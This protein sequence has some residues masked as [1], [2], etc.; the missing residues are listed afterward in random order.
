MAKKEAN[1]VIR[2]RD[3]ASA[4]FKSITSR[5]KGLLTPL[6]LATAALGALG[7][8]LGGFSLAAAIRE[9]GDFGEQ[10]S[11]LGGL[12]QAT[13]E[14]LQAME[15][16]ARE[17]GA[18]TRFTATEAGRGLEELA[19]G[20]Q[21]VADSIQSLNPVLSL[22]AGNNQT[23]A[24]SAQ[25]VVTALNAFGLAADE[26]G[27]VADV[28]TRAAQRT[29]QTT[30]ELAQAMTMVAP[31]AKAA[32]LSIEETSAIIGRL[33]DQGFRG[34]L[35]GTALRNAL[36]DLENPS[37]NFRAELQN[38]GVTSTNF[39]D[40]LG[41][42]AE[43]GDESEQALR[44]LGRRSGPAIQ[45][46]VQSGSEG[47][48]E[49]VG[50]L[51]QAEGAASSAA[52]AMED[53][54]P[55]AIRSL[56][57]AFADAQIEATSGLVDKLKDAV[58]DLA[59]GIRAFTRS[60]SMQQL[61]GLLV[62]TFEAAQHTVS[63]FIKSVDFEQIQQHVVS[64]AQEVRD[65]FSQ[66]R[67]TADQ[68]ASGFRVAFGV[69]E[70]AT[71]SLRI[72]FN[73]L[74]VLIGR[75]IDIGLRGSEQL[76]KAFNRATLGLSQ[77]AK[78]IEAD[79]GGFRESVQGSIDDF[80]A[81]LLD[82]VEQIGRG[83]DRIADTNREG[84]KKAS[85]GVAD[86]LQAQTERIRRDFERLRDNAGGVEESLDSLGDSAAGTADGF[87]VASESIRK[88]GDALDELPEKTERARTAAGKVGDEWV[89]IN[90]A[91]SDAAESQKDAADS[92]GR[93][94]SRTRDAADST[95]KLG[96]ES[97]KTTAASSRLGGT[98][99]MGAAAQERFNQA[100]AAWQGGGVFTYIRHY[101]QALEEAL[102]VQQRVEK[103]QARL[104]A[105]QDQ[106]VDITTDFAAANR[107]LKEELMLVRG[108][109]EELARLRAREQEEALRAQLALA[110]AEGDKARVE[111]VREHLRL[112]QELSREQERQDQ[113]ES[114]RARDREREMDRERETA[115][116]MERATSG[117]GRIQQE[118]SV[119]VQSAIGRDGQPE[120]ARADI[121]RIADA[122]VD[123]I[124][125]DQRRV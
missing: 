89:R 108:Q 11:V 3:Q 109:E 9:A 30:G 120:F 79:I 1:I 113:Q 111:Q 39:I 112:Q 76:V 80:Q 27:R 50:E 2:L 73:A 65:R 58:F 86:E 93:Q 29:A 70:A 52:S 81:G 4:G 67:V 82:G 20:G 55:G 99:E 53:N 95:E 34:S 6:G 13:A 45:A 8:V 105:L 66:L 75:V 114:Q 100:M 31:A 62:D 92:L 116:M 84:A 119:T 69:V 10:L 21:S 117:S 47:L 5:V 51:Q 54:L 91:A 22:A 106:G 96:E 33:A 12:T 16:A 37:S 103:A 104:N 77:T 110:Q 41:E 49:L 115:R 90:T 23:V 38:L 72:G 102:D 40:V 35:G 88:T 46:L 121:Q 7:G 122:V 107:R 14:E 97:R 94:A 32:D 124:E 56:K 101:K 78:Q 63:E 17:A 26:S 28:Y 48:R 15:A 43:R 125:I 85:E 42:L 64:F 19:R 25:Q 98:I 44:T 57:S 24:E 123:M 60:E 83:W 87:D 36:I 59:D 118:I 74:G 68:F 18:T 61:R 71:G